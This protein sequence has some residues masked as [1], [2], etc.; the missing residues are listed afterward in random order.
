MCLY[1]CACACARPGLGHITGS[2]TNH[3]SQEVGGNRPLK[4]KDG[5]SV[6]FVART[7]TL[8]IR[9]SGD[10]KELGGWLQA[11]PTL[12]AFQLLFIMAELRTCAYLYCT[13]CHDRCVPRGRRQ[14][15]CRTPM[16]SKVLECDQRSS[17]PSRFPAQ[18]LR[19]HL[20]HADAF[21]GNGLS[22]SLYT[23]P[24]QLYMRIYLLRSSS[25]TVAC[26]SAWPVTKLIT[27]VF[28][29]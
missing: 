11:P 7:E 19:A 28:I 27:P 15:W 6:L 2:W 26:M 21:Q 5:T 16:H 3:H 25:K 9:E 22:G 13:T 23:F 17:C 1:L 20:E 14:S 12:P 4:A 8:S 18:E 24:P 10:I 29:F